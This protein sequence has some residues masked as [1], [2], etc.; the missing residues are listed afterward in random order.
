[1]DVSS[2]AEVSRK[3]QRRSN[4]SKFA[5]LLLVYMYMMTQ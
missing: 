3:L 4:S 1:M 5:F 2:M